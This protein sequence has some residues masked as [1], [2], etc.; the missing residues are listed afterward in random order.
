M[1]VRSI[2]TLKK[3]YHR[4]KIGDEGPIHLNMKKTA[5]NYGGYLDGEVKG[6]PLMAKAR[7]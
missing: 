7:G 4:K 5:F 2:F 1:K 6:K 3:D